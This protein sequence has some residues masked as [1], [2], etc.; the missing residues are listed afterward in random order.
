[1]MSD[2]GAAVPM[3]AMINSILSECVWGTVSDA[4]NTT[5]TWE[6][7]SPIPSKNPPVTDLI[8]YGEFLEN[9]LRVPKIERKHAKTNFTAEGELL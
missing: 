7:N 2:P 3:S 6:M 4:E 9:V 5:P 8:S 1:M